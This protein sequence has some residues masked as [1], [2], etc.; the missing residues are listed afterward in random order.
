M[1]FNYIIFDPSVVNI[2]QA[3]SK[4]E[5]GGSLDTHTHIYTRT[6]THIHIH[7]YTYIHTYIFTHD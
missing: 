1:K 6:L 3:G 7:T 4:I 2:V 5:N